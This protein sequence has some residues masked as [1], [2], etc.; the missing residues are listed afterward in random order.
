MN[1]KKMQIF[2]GLIVLVICVFAGAFLTTFVGGKLLGADEKTSG[3][4]FQT[5]ASAEEE[6]T[7]TG[8][9]GNIFD[10]R[11]GNRGMKDERLNITDEEIEQLESFISEKMGI[12]EIHPDTA[13]EY[14]IEDHIMRARYGLVGT[15]S[16]Y[17]PQPDCYD[18]G[19]EN[20]PDEYKKFYVP[21]YKK[22]PLG[23]FES[24]A[25]IPE[26]DI[27]WMC[28]NIYNRNYDVPAEGD[29]YFYI[30]DGSCYIMLG[31]DGAENPEVK[32]CSSEKNSDGIYNLIFELY[33]ASS[34]T[35]EY[36]NISMD[37]RMID[38]KRCM[39]FYL[40]L[41]TSAVK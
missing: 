24:Y 38:G 1:N 7:T 19:Y 31:P 41:P 15:Y 28:E 22:D 27:I 39:T 36:I 33:N 13:A 17:F 25:V 14:I 3:D 32:L 2:V 26:E 5:T 9:G 37:V 34:D 4:A 11:Y 40:I 18:P 21:D 6:N 16:L 20:I 35:T 12:G 10:S 29:K 30:H 8:S 23:K